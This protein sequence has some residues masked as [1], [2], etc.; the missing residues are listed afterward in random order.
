MQ[1]TN[2]S[3]ED[4]YTWVNNNGAASDKTDTT[5]K[6]TSGDGDWWTVAGHLDCWIVKNGTVWYIMHTKYFD[7]LF[8]AV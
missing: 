7:H 1:C 2:S 8:E 3:F 4:V 6:V 5:F